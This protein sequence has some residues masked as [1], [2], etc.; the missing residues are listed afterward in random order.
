MPRFQHGNR[1]RAGALA[2]VLV[3]VVFGRVEIRT[4]QTG[5]GERRVWAARSQGRI[6][7][8]RS[9]AADN[10]VEAQ[11][12]EGHLSRPVVDRRAWKI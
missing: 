3:S 6:Q 8:V 7:E 9:N 2:G 4:K 10:A 12:S 11:A 5:F 1:T